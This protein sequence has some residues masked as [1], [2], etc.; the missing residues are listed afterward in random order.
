MRL[1]D[2][3]R[4]RAVWLY[5][6]IVLAYFY[7][8]LTTGTFYFRDLYRLFY[9]KKLFFA[10]MIRSGQLPLWDPTTHGGLP[11]LAV[12]SNFAFHPS[13]V[14]YAVLPA[15]AAFNIVLVLHI[16]FCAIAAY[17]L[18]RV[19]DLPAPA[20]FV[21][22]IAFAFCG[23]TLSTANLMPLLLGLPWMPL[24]IGLAHRALRTS[25][26]LFPAAIAAAMPLYSAAA[27][28]TAMLFALL[29]V[30]LLTERAYPRR[31]SLAAACFVIAGGIG[32][33][34]LQTL[35]ATSVIAQSPRSEGRSYESFTTWSVAPQRLPELLV[36]RF[37]GD[38][39]TLVETRLWGR[40][41]EYIGYPY[42]IS[43]YLGVPLLLLAA[44]GARRRPALALF[45][46]VALLLSLGRH[47]PGFRLIY[48]YIPF[49]SIF[50]YPVKAQIAALLPI[51]ILGAFGVQMVVESVPLRRR[52]MVIASVAA[53]AAAAIAGLLFI[54][55]G[56][57]SAFAETLSFTP[58]GVSER[59][60]LARA[61]V[62]AAV[63]AGCFAAAVA[64]G[65]A[66]AIAAV[67]ALDLL[68]AGWGVNDFAPREL[69]DEPSLASTARAAVGHGRFHSGEKP[70][71]VPAPDD[72]LM[73]LARWQIASL[74]SY[75]APLFGMPAVYH[76]DYDGLGPA[77]MARLGTRIERVPW[78]RR[79]L[80]F[81]RANVRAFLTPAVVAAP[82]LAQLAALS[83]P[84]RLYANPG[85]V[86]ARFVS[87]AV[88]ANGE[89][90]AARRLL[91]ERDLSRVVLEETPIAG[92]C[93]TTPVSVQSRANSTMRYAVDAPCNGYV[94]FAENHY[95]GWSATV[96]GRPAR[97][98]RAD[99]AF[100]AVA[101]PSGRHVIERRYFPP[102]LYAGAAG[103]LVTAMLLALWDRRR[104]RRQ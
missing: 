51:A 49:V 52:A 94:V 1:R 87:S 2:L 46:A 72:D 27:E 33:S 70:L 22:G 47:L 36:P 97:L 81:D 26:S 104:L 4:D 16:L 39:D 15:L 93:G 71:L 66:A 63:A 6:A 89:R 86:E 99:Y 101:V 21:A 75:N 68:A 55:P 34:L 5:T 56:F 19:L 41:L 43:L 67:V 98:L 92:N 54:A 8:P 40:E 18:A 24:T 61:F 85:A 103:V 84:L 62:H 32:L 95:D 12:P 44:L 29:A 57:S 91:A 23:Y 79:K 25:R 83:G 100:T 35:P 17:W 80:L 90:D 30:W 74:N 42:I 58:L 65:R 13:N 3:V 77:R 96:D 69:F 59:T 73:W 88:V 45:A 53:A 28:L 7:S 64:S 82:E 48:D 11:Y 38:T 14:L 20:A 50:R 37:L 76:D 9:P 102:R 60:L 10:E 31:K 78:D